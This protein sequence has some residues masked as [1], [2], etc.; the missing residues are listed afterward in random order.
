[1]A[2]SEF[3]S[4][5]PSGLIAIGLDEGDELGWVRLT[6]GEDDI[7]LVTEKGQALRFTEDEVRPMGRTAAG[8]TGIR[9]ED[10][11]YVTSMEVVRARAIC[12][13]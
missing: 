1:M 12:W 7:I 6:Q 5:R 4:V 10:G 2:L 3:A 13:F 11:D 8:V 9:L